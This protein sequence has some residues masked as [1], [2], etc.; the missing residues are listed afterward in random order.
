MRPDG[1]LLRIA[2]LAIIVLAVWSLLPVIVAILG[3]T[4]AP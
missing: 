3:H 1:D 2:A 4:S